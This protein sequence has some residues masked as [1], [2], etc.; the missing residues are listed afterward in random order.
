MMPS[1]QF[2]VIRNIF[3]VLLAGI[4]IFSCIDGMISSGNIVDAVADEDICCSCACCESG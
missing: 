4:L 2:E 3:L 1:E